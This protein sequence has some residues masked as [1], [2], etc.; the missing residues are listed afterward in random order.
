MTP[1]F[2][3]KR[4]LVTGGGTGIGRVTALALATQGCFRS[5]ALEYA[6]DGIRVN[7]VC[8]ALVDTPLIHDTDGNLFDYI[9]PLIAAHPMGRIA[10]PEEIADAIIW[11]CSDKSSYVTGAALPVDGR[12][13][14]Q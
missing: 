3:G 9:T 2:D 14:A 5:A 1:L 13:T 8:P 12:Y 7:A 4:A 10:Q 11:L 6:A